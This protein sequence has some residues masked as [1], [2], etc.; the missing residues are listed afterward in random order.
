MSEKKYEGE[1]INAE[2]LFQSSCEDAEKIVNDPGK[3]DKLL[4]RLAR[5]LQ[6]GPK[7]LKALAYIPQMG[8]LVNSFVRHEYTEIPV[9]ILIAIVGVLA[10]FVSPIDA[11]PDYLPFGIGL[12]DDAAVATAAMYL[13]KSD[14]DE[15]MA[16]RA[17][18]GLGDEEC[19]M[20]DNVVLE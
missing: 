1:I 3:I 14:L 19:F 8:M 15:Y 11:I 13:I 10:Y 7:L 2:E 17:S 12:V 6:K 4:K 16:W 9:G 5:K 20:P 18:R